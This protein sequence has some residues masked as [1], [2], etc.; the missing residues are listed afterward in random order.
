MTIVV[1]LG[2]GAIVIDAGALYQERRELQNGA[3]AAVLAVARNCARLNCGDEDATADHFADENATDDAADAPVVCGDSP[4]L[5]SC[6]ATVPAPA[7]A[8]GWVRVET[9]T[10]NP[11]NPTDDGQVELVLAPL[12]DAANVG[13]TVEATAVATW[14]PVRESEAS[15]FTISTC[16]FY[17]LGGSLSPLVVPGGNTVID[18]RSSPTQSA[19]HDCGFDSGG[20]AWLDVG[21]DCAI[22]IDLTG[23]TWIQRGSRRSNPSRLGCDASDWR[24][25]EVLVTLYDETR[26]SPRRF[27]VSGFIGF[28]ITGYALGGSV[29][30]SPDCTVPPIFG[31]RCIE[32]R[33]TRIIAADGE[34]G[35][36]G[37]DYGARAVEMI[38]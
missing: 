26:T 10:H 23:T 6:S 35:E 20:F 15:P 25:A 2:V 24:N 36:A 31:G 30:N 34:M 12:L 29:W 9:S 14:G 28:R 4:G 19:A 3:D 21:G 27:H 18:F 13:Q 5:P 8:L 22:T 38:G 37:D 7:D 17:A 32:G 1:L 11:G 33:F 16:E